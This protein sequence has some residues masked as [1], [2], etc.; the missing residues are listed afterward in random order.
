MR[1]ANTR[2]TL[3]IV[4]LSGRYIDVPVLP[5]GYAETYGPF[6]QAVPSGTF[7]VLVNGTFNAGLWE[8]RIKVVS[9]LEDRTQQT[10]LVPTPTT[11]TVLWEL[12][13]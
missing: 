13:P 10:T 2:G 8:H 4:E 9:T 11:N 5:G 7:D 6:L 1:L 12:A 3:L